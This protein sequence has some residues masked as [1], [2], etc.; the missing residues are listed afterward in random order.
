MSVLSGRHFLQIPGPKNVPDCVPRVLSRTAIDHH[1]LEFSSLAVDVL[2]DMRRMFQTSGTFVIF[3]SS[4]TGA[5]EAAR[6]A[7]L[8][9]RTGTSRR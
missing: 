4:G 3:S 2:D 1:G 9:N 6:F 7:K 8:A 5:W